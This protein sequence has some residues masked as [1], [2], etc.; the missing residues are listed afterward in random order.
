[1]ISTKDTEDTHVIVGTAVLLQYKSTTSDKMGADTVSNSTA[2]PSNEKPPSSPVTT[3]EDPISNAIGEFG[4]WQFQLTVLLSLLNIPCTWHIF[5]LTFQAADQNFWC[6]QTDNF[7]HISFP[8]WINIS[9]VFTRDDEKF[10]YNPC[11]I[12]DLDYSQSYHDLLLE[13]ENVTTTRPCQKW[14]YDTNNFGDTIIS[15]WNLVCTR[16]HLKSLAEMM[17]LLG[18]A[19]GGFFSGLVSD[20]FGRKRALMGSLVC[21]LV[22]GAGVAASPWFEGYLVLRA[23]LGFVCVSIVFSGFVLCM[24]IVGGKWLTIAGISY[25]FPV[26]LGYI[27]ISGIAYY[28]H[29]W[30]IL[31]WV[32]TAPTI[33]FLILWW[34]IPESPRWLLTMGKTEEAME[35]LKDAARFNDKTLPANTDKLLKQSVSS[36]KEDS[37]KKVEVLDLWRT[38]LMRLISCVQ[39]VVWFSVYLVYYGLVLNLS[40]IGGDVYVNTVISGI[41]EIPAIAM[42]IL[43][44][45]KMGRRRPL[46]LTTMAAGV[47]CLVT[48]AFPQ[49]SWMTISLAMIGKFAISSSNVVM[50]VYTAELFPT[51]MRNLGV[52]ASSVPAGVALILIPYLWDMEF[53]HIHF[54][55]VL[56]GVSGIVGGLSVLLLPDTTGLSTEVN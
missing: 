9:G 10:G 15:E 36:M 46:C 17:F 43:I 24:E 48:L 14:L 34:C 27:A 12:K 8:E 32:I 28:I 7:D 53:F 33:I 26:P 11:A 51:K 40:N 19:F 49:G 42:S 37:G 6:A 4:R 23:M 55:M 2:T 35:V 54:P 16:A 22:L 25:L 41:V 13:S 3:N 39:Y 50:P 5:A 31:Q 44:L 18:V 38:P 21:Q 45:L 52:G 56:L 20:R 30:R 29:S 47:A 1:M